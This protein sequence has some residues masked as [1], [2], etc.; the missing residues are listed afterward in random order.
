MKFTYFYSSKPRGKGELARKA[1]GGL[2]R[3]GVWSEDLKRK[4]GDL[5]CKRRQSEWSEGGS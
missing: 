5:K 2:E 3:G 1:K 4:R